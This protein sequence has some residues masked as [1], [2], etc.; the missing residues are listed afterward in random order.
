MNAIILKLTTHLITG[1]IIATAWLAY[2][3]SIKAIICNYC[4]ITVLLS[5][6]QY[7]HFRTVSYGRLTKSSDEMSTKISRILVSVF[8]LWSNFRHSFSFVDEN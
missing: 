6:E 2:L 8:V 4:S 5:A 1:V 7:T 3:I